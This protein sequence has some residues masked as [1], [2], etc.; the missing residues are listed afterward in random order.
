M[1][2][3]GNAGVD[4]D[5]ER[6]DVFIGEAQVAMQGAFIPFDRDAVVQAMGA[7]EV[8]IRLNLNRGRAVGRAWGCDL[9]EGY[10]KINAE[11]TT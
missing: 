1:M 3:V 4:L 2:A 8:Q 10:V 9:T 7:N 6:I 11:Y 5:P